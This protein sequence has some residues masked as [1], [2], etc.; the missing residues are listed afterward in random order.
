MAEYDYDVLVIGAGPGGYVAAIRAAQ[1]GL[2]TACA[3]SRETLGGTCLNVGCIPSKAM[4][5]A[6]EYFDAASNGTM[7]HMGIEVKPKLNLDTMHAQRRDAVKGLTGG[8]EFL[9]KKNKVDWKKGHAT[10]QDAHTVKV[11]DETVTAKNVIIATGSSVTPLPGVE[12]DNDKQVVVDSTGALELKSVPK[13]MVVIGGGVIGLELGSVWRRLGAEVIVVEFLDKL[14]PGMDD[15][16]RKEAAKI[17][18][19]QGMELRLSTKVTGCTVKGKKATLTLEPA[20]GGDSETLDADCV[21]VSIGRR[22]NTDKL[23]LENIGLELNKRGQIETDH[24]FRTKVDGVWAIGDVIPGPMLAHKAED[25]GIACAENVAGQT[26]IVNH[27]LIP[28]VVYTWPEFAGVGLTEAEALE[29]AG[30]DKAKIKV[31][32]FPMMANSRAKTN[33]EPEGFV[34]VIADA[35]SDRVLGVWCIASVAGTMIA[36]ATQ[37]MEFGATSEDIAYTCHAH[38][39]HSE[40]IKEAAMAVQGKPIHM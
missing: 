2:K 13:K 23:G 7:E 12:V 19:K 34:K 15:D 11:G 31:G 39:T 32:K 38:P 9:F 37:A 40:A 8:I 30:G 26:G 33:H 17:F 20:A 35:D 21:L 24:D 6:S 29:K 28:G 27:D 22:P 3:E 36:Q 5:H 10:F 14:L 1:L 4:L 25:E 16:V 18:K